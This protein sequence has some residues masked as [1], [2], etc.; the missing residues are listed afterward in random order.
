MQSAEESKS[1]PQNRLVRKVQTLCCDSSD[2]K[3]FKKVFV[4]GISANAFVD[5]GSSCNTMVQSF[6]EK[7]GLELKSNNEVVIKGYGDALIVPM[8]IV[9]ASLVV[10]EVEQYNQFY[11]VP[12]N[13][14]NMDVLIGQTFTESPNIVVVKTP[15]KLNIYNNEMALQVTELCNTLEKIRLFPQLDTKLAPGLNKILVRLDP[16][17]NGTLNIKQSEQRKPLSEKDVLEDNVEIRDGCVIIKL[18][19]KTT[20]DID[21]KLD[22]CIARAD[23]LKDD[24]AKI[25]NFKVGKNLDDCEKICLDELLAKYN[26]CFSGN[27]MELGNCSVEMSIKLTEDKVINYKPNRLSFHERD[28]VKDIIDNL[29][30]AGI[31]ETSKSPFA[32]PVV[33]VK[34]KGRWLQIM[35]GL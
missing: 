5:F 14:Q 9:T 18:M 20:K 35:C 3:Y 33:L 6:Y 12:D 23:L 31:I 34:K 30:K 2:K 27:G 25:D 1:G 10:D 11:V 16:I 8:G 13:V 21:L 29:L 19:N 32:S 24:V 17:V 15:D 4:N 28:I 22:E 7:L 26:H